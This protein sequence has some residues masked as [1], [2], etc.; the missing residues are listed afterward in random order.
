[1][2]RET[3][4]GDELS[5]VL[6]GTWGIVSL[7]SPEASTRS[8][9]ALIKSRVGR[10]DRLA[11]TRRELRDDLEGV[12]RSARNAGADTLALS[13]EILPGVPFPASLVITDIPLRNQEGRVGDDALTRAERLTAHDPALSHIDLRQ[14]PT[15]RTTE[16]KMI[17]VGES[18]TPQVTC[19]YTMPIPGRALAKYVVLCA[20]MAEAGDLYVDLFDAMADSMVWQEPSMEPVA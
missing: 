7:E 17:T 9:V 10:D 8:I 5:I 18:E 3:R 20:P 15:G 19:R 6:P 12:A 2:T 14:G 4:L 16:T 11:R 13:M 1:M